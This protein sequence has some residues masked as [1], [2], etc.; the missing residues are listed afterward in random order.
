MAKR[1]LS[2]KL[3]KK[4]DIIEDIRL[5]KNS[6]TDYITP[7]G[8]IYK[9]Y[10]NG[11]FFPKKSHINKYNGYVYAKITYPNENKQRRV[12]ILVAEAWIPN[13]DNKPIVMHK[14]NNKQNNTID[15]LKW[16]TVSENTQQAYNDGLAKNAKGF[17][18]NQSQP[19]IMYDTCTRE[20]LKT[21]G[22]CRIC[23]KENPYNLSLHAIIEQCKKHTP[24]R[25]KV[26]FR[27]LKDGNI[28]PPQIII[29]YDYDT[30]KEI[31]RYWNS[32]DAERKTKISYKTISQQCKNN[33]KPKQK[34]KSGYYFMYG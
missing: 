3:I 33:F 21:F 12:H 5:I 7:T 24:V 8:K 29:Q 27:F 32:L 20:P 17:E 16:G 9:D 31:N 22:S 2:N 15:N 13:F 18:D 23:A 4:E 11:L 28:N 25:H 10:G 34:T 26:Y 30:N 6:C 14:D 19:V 1:K